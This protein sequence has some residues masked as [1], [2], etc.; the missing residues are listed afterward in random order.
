MCF[1]FIQ[2]FI[3]GDFASIV[4]ALEKWKKAKLKLISIVMGGKM[5]PKE[6]LLFKNVFNSFSE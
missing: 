6:K 5:H 2:I 3:C 4:N 1:I